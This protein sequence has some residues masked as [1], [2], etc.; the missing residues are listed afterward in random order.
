MKYYFICFINK[1]RLLIHNYI[2]L[3]TYVSFNFELS[4]ETHK[5]LTFENFI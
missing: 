2:H 5:N 1:L 3:M 4:L